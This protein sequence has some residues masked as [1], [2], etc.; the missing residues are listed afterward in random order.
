VYQ[1]DLPDACFGYAL[2]GPDPE[3]KVRVNRILD[4]DRNVYPAKGIG[5]FLD[6]EGVNRRAGSQPKHVHI[7]M[8]SIFDLFTGSY[9]H[10]NRNA[11]KFPGMLQPWQALGTNA[12]E[13]TRTGPGLPDPC[14]HDVHLSGLVQPNGGFHNLFFSFCT[15]GSRNN[16][17]ALL[18]LFL[19]QGLIVLRLRCLHV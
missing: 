16:Q 2:Y 6:T 19:H 15:T 12:F 17:R 13:T 14:S 18:P 9:F 5:H 11:R 7:K 1:T 8:E 4:K 3:F 10:G